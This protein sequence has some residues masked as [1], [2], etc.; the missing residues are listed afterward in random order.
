MRTRGGRRRCWIRPGIEVQVHCAGGG[1][2]PRRVR[3]GEC[4]AILRAEDWYT[5]LLEDDADRLGPGSHGS[6]TVTF[7]GRPH[8]AR[9]EVRANA[10]WRRGRVFLICGRCGGR[11]TR[12]YLPLKTSWLACRRCWGPTYSSRTLLNYKDSLWGLRRFAAFFGTT[13]RE[14]PF[15]VTE[16]WARDRLAAAAKRWAQ[17]RGLWT[18]KRGGN[19]RFSGSGN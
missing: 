8:T 5:A 13:Q 9:W 16:E 19:A 10:V 12:L 3:T 18:S 11:C 1:W 2:G 17:R 14:Y 4:Y 6:G 7:D 15:S